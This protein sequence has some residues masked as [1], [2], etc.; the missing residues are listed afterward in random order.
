M[1]PDDLCA[2]AKY[3]VFQITSLHMLTNIHIAQEIVTNEPSKKVL[4]WTNV[5]FSEHKYF[6]DELAE[7]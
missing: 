5:C 7:F 1:L 4:H 6:K 2:F 3:W